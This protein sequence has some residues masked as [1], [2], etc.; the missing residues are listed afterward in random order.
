MACGSICFNHRLNITWK[1]SSPLIARDGQSTSGGISTSYPQ[2][3]QVSRTCRLLELSSLRE[4]CTDRQF[5]YCGGASGSQFCSKPS[6]FCLKSDIKTP[7]LL[8]GP[9]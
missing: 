1:Y 8:I 5:P 9:A 4:G 2:G 3:C 7:S 6:T